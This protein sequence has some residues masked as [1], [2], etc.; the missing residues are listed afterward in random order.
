MSRT[1][2]DNPAAYLNDRPLLS[3]GGARLLWFAASTVI[4]LLALW[5]AHLPFLSRF[6]GVTLDWRF[7]A[8]GGKD[9]PSNIVLVEIDEESRRS[10]R[11]ADGAFDLRA[12]LAAAVDHLAE[13]GALVV[14]LDVWFEDPTGRDSDQKLA[15]AISRANVVL[16]VTHTDGKIKRAPDIFLSAGPKEGVVTVYPDAGNVLR[17]L[18][19]SLYLNVLGAN[20]AIAEELPHFPLMLAWFVAAEKN[21]DIQIEF[22]NGVAKIG[23][24]QAWPGELIDFASLNRA[25]ANET[26]KGWHTLRLADVVT[27][28]FDRTGL[29]GAVVM[30]GE[31]RSIQD[32]F[33]MPLSETMVPGLYYH[34]N[35]L[36]HILRGAHFDEQ[37]SRQP[38]DIWLSAALAFVA[39]IFAWNPRPWWRRRRGSALL[40]ATYIAVGVVLFLGGWAYAC[41]R[42]FDHYVV[43]PMV[44]PMLCMSLAIGSGMVMQWIVLTANAQR[45]EERN[46]R[47]ELLFGQSVSDK[48]L[49]ALRQNP[50]AIRRVETREVS[51]LFCDLRNYTSA[52]ADL[53]PTAAAEMLNEYFTFITMAIFEHD[54][55]ID[56]F[57]GDEVMAVFSVPFTQEDHPLRAVRTAIAV[58]QRLADLNRVRVERGQTQLDCGLGIH[59]GPVAAGHIGTSRRSNYT[60]I[61]AT[62]NRAAR[63]EG[64]TRGGEILISD[65]VRERL[66]PDIAIR[67]WRRVALRGF[68]DTVDLHEVVT[69]SITAS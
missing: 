26:S 38:R 50:E 52:T 29:D 24:Y 21:P 18:P 10:L 32:A 56:K 54:G 12:S 69:D 57:V 35:A 17:R 14:G 8:R 40:L 46:R 28:K 27:G 19:E 11:P 7:R 53:E 67:F 1:D 59:C 30:I 63:I 5:L 31:S 13:A 68:E 60:V 64:L 16:A 23:P 44:G 42:L 58:K 4:A 39:A 65:A 61:G 33:V 36:A 49:E 9:V 66:P 51:V 3:P 43:L 22:T 34:A 41:F 2:V 47:I 45:L 55:F 25:T 20:G 37:W 62:V 15:D 48:M 6:E